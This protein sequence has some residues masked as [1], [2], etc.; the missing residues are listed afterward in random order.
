MRDL[1]AVVI[2]GLLGTG[3]RFAVDGVLLH[4]DDQFPLST[5]IAN[6]LGAFALGFLVAR[7]WPT[8]P[9]WLRA[10]LGVGL[11]G[12]FTTF[13]AVAVSL[14]SLTAAGWGMLALAYLVATIV[15]G[16]AAA[17][18]GLRLGRVRGA[19]P[20]DEPVPIDEVDE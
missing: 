17:W 1:L 18:L 7:V 2:G 9:S 11:L 15:L 4:Q 12:S 6:A 13:S 8:A 10:G 16:L 5:L 19:V 20:G 3:A 14:V